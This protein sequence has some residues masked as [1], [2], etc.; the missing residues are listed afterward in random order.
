MED[1]KVIKIETKGREIISVGKMPF[2]YG[3]LA[4]VVGVVV[5]LIS[6]LGSIP[7]FIVAGWLFAGGWPLES[8][9][10][11]QSATQSEARVTRPQESTPTVT[12]PPEPAQVPPRACSEPTAPIVHEVI[13]NVQKP[14]IPRG[15]TEAPA[16]GAPTPKQGARE[17]YPGEKAVLQTPPARVKRVRK[18]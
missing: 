5:G 15:R 14:V 6:H 12:R 2:L 11:G 4:T 8:P 17:E 9:T 16:E 18:K 3:M 7:C 13:P 10:Q 1:N